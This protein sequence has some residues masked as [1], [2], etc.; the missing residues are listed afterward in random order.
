M[1]VSLRYMLSR[2][3]KNMRRNLFSNGATIGVIAISV[4]IF[5]AFSLIA[6]NLL[7]HP[8]HIF[9]PSG[10]IKPPALC[11]HSR[12]SRAQTPVQARES[13]QQHPAV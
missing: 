9:R 10:V 11:R 1:K 6:F 8:H 2:A 5:S 12:S 13:Q 7:N 3:L 4:L